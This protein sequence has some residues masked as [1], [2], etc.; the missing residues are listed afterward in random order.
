MS[1][2]LESTAAQLLDKLVETVSGP[3]RGTITATATS[4]TVKVRIG[5]IATLPDGR[6]VRVIKRTAV[7]TTP[8]AVPCRL[9]LLSPASPAAANFKAV[10]IGTV[11]TWLS[12][13]AGLAATGTTSAFAAGANA[14]SLKIA[15]LVEHDNASSPPEI[16]AA[17]AQ[18]TAALILL[19]PSV[20]RIGPDNLTSY[21]LYEATWR[22]RLC[23]FDV[24]EEKIRRTRARNTFD[25]IAASVLN[26]AAG[27][28]SVRIGGWN[29]VRETGWGTSAWEAT[30]LTR[31]EVDG[32]TM[33]DAA[34]E[35]DFEGADVTVK[36]PGDSDQPS[37]FRVVEDVDAG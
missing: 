37:P 11:A 27:D 32:R 36:I 6:R 28:D 1:S 13:P 24:A 21:G 15:A 17:G 14:G 5:Q 10:A 19:S 22:L 3:V 7:S 29:P 23:L 26:A 12:P 2:T 31:L 34:A 9:E 8:T 35:A 18:G 20:R 16:F 33:R 25:A 30:L 4:G